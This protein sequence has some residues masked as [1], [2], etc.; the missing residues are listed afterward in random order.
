MF[1]MLQAKWQTV[2]ASRGAARSSLHCLHIRASSIGL[3]FIL[4]TLETV[5]FLLV[6]PFTP[7][8]FTQN[9]T[10]PVQQTKRVIE[11][12]RTEDIIDTISRSVNGQLQQTNGF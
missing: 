6:T 9:K 12:E 1:E 8:A 4:F 3:I 2:Q 5:Q 10:F 7:S 11:A